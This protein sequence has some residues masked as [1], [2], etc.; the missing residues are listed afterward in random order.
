M[1]IPIITFS[2][3]SFFR[4][5]SDVFLAKLSEV[6]QNWR[7]EAQPA[8]NNPIIYLILSEKTITLL[9]RIEINN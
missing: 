2:V 6:P 7:M 8:V 3:L 4:G 1:H 9:L 5:T